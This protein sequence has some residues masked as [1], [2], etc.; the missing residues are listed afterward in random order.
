MPLRLSLGSVA[1]DN[2]EAALSSRL[3]LLRTQ[4]DIAYGA[5]AGA[6]A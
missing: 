2:I 1:F 4:R 5:D 3:E 6:R